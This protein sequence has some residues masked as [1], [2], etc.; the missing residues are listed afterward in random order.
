MKNIFIAVVLL[1]AAPVLAQVP[2]PG[3]RAV[4]TVGFI[5]NGSYF[6]VKGS[7]LLTN[8][9]VGSDQTQWITIACVANDYFRDE[10]SEHSQDVSGAKIVKF[11]FTHSLELEEF[12]PPSSGTDISCTLYAGFITEKPHNISGTAKRVILTVSDG[13]IL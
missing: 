3:A 13:Q 6:K 12:N 7:A 10:H 9:G 8:D 5:S 11:S 2:Y 1:C 4:Q